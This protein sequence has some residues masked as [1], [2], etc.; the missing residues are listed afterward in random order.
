MIDRLKLH[1]GMRLAEQMLKRP[2]LPEAAR[3]KFKEA[4]DHAEMALILDGAVRRKL[5]KKKPQNNG[6]G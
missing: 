6:A 4:R 1:R 2:E 3:Q 5:A